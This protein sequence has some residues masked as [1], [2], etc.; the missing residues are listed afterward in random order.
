MS[1]FLKKIKQRYFTRDGDT[2]Y[3][4]ALKRIVFIF[5]IF[6]FFLAIGILTWIK[7][8]QRQG[9]KIKVP[10]ITG[11]SVLQAAEILQ[12]RR[13]NLK[14]IPVIK[15]NVPKYNIVQQNPAAGTTVREN[16]VI[17]IVVSSGQIFSRMPSFIGKSLF[18]VKQLFMGQKQIQGMGKVILQKITYVPSDSPINTII[19]QTPNPETPIKNDVP[20]YLVVS[21]G[22]NHKTFILPDYSNKYF[23][24]AVK[25][26][27][28]ND[29]Y[30]VVKSI[31][32]SQDK[33]GK[34][35]S[36]TP[37]R[38]IRVSPGQRVTLNVGT[39]AKSKVPS[40]AKIISY[41]VPKTGQ[42]DNDVKIVLSDDGYDRI[43][44]QGSV[45][46]GEKVVQAV[47]VRGSAR[48]KIFLNTKLVRDENL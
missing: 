31:Q 4:G 46:N 33:V 8:I 6:L 13:L 38:G 2:L 15:N 21:N 22:M 45:K 30:V 7:F 48:Y 25:E 27:T 16:R 47:M 44:F 5:I 39:G 37:A 23:Y 1:H 11:I 10:R 35:L 14:I 12:K 3:F 34:V 18:K 43:L 17:E 29:I 28:F 36:Q 42:S 41:I 26:L 19:A 32:S 40:R 20:V 9:G 24:R